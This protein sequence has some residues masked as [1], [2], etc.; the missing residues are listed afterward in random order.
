MSA[1]APSDAPEHEQLGDMA[2]PPPNATWVS[3]ARQST[4]LFVVAV[5]LIIAL[6][7]GSS[8]SRRY[9]S[10]D[11]PTVDIVNLQRVDV[12]YHMLYP[13]IEAKTTFGETFG[14]YREPWRDDAW[15]GAYWRP[16]TMQAWWL[17]AHMFGIDRP[18]NWMRISLLL[19]VAFD[20]LLL[21][22][23]WNLTKSR[24]LALI[25]LALFAL[26]SWIHAWTPLS[27]RP[28]IGF[29][30]LLILEWKD[31]PDLFANC[32]ILGALILAIRGRFAFALL[33]GA[34]A[35]GFKESGLMSFPLVFLAMAWTGRVKQIPKWCYAATAALLGLMMVGRWFAGPLVFR[36]HS[37][38]GHTG[39][40]TRYTN[41]MLPLG[42]GA[43]VSAGQTLAGAGLFGLMAWRPKG[44]IVWTLCVLGLLGTSVVLVSW[45]NGL[46]LDVGF[47][48]LIDTGTRPILLLLAW[49]LVFALLWRNKFLFKWAMF[50]AA[51]AYLLA[52]PFG[53]ATQA[54]E[55]VLTLARAFQCAYGACVLL[56]TGIALSEALK[57]LRGYFLRAPASET[58]LDPTTRT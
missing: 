39:A 6:S 8:P 14:W 16:L 50:F 44:L 54:A 32:F 2:A 38:G 18:Y 36:F 31:Q 29:S 52:L 43:L 4:A 19:A 34:L 15:V 26:P 9:F 33:C 45:Q 10:L 40:V 37:Y 13:S 48:Q 35:I 25:A 28:R 49:L 24:L 42:F 1:L 11:N 21:S 30:D 27:E 17:Q 3:R 20:V 23:V 51:S 53:M 7:L 41:A 57:Y 58:I 22:L 46:P 12:D 56:A 55:H 5:G 47:A